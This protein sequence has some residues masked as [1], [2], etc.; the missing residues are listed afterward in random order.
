M[1]SPY[2]MRPLRTE[3]EARGMELQARRDRQKMEHF[4]RYEAIAQEIGIDALWRLVPFDR[5]EIDR[6]LEAG[7]EHL[8]SLRLGAWDACDGFLRPLGY[9]ARKALNGRA[10]WSLSDTVCTLKHVAKHHRGPAEL[11]ASLAA[12]DEAHAAWE[13]T[14]RELIF[15]DAKACLA[16]VANAQAKRAAYEAAKAWHKAGD[17]NAES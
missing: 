9:R 13:K 11:E 15:A 16:K 14:D 8:N 12:W 5:A 17:T 10:V 4:A 6:A 3:I 7:D 2:L 1:T